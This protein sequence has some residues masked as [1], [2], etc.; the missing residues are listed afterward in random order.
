MTIGAGV[1]VYRTWRSDASFA[2]KATVLCLGSLLATPYC[3]DYDLMAL[4]PAIALLVS[5]GLA[6]GFLPYERFAA[7]I[8]WSVPILARPAAQ[9]SLLPLGAIVCLG[10]LLPLARLA[11]AQELEV[12]IPA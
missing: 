7:A 3:Y 6:N 5:D 9:W 11:P 1:I 12:A 2:R 4:A 10:T 8:L